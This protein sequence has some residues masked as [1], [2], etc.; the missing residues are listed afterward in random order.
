MP[1]N[2]PGRD[3]PKRQTPTFA[4]PDRPPLA[5][6][7]KK[8]LITVERKWDEIVGWMPTGWFAASDGDLLRVYCETWCDWE[9]A[10]RG[11]RKHGRVDK[12]PGGRSMISGHAKLETDLLARLVALSRDLGL[13]TPMSRRVSSATTQPGGLRLLD[14]AK[15][16]T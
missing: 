8:M 4:A 7:A 16:R 12:S 13:T 6:P 15:G 1:T 11:A 9:K 5:K 10:R 14:G 2:A 3:G